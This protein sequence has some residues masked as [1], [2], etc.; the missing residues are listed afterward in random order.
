VVG[1]GPPGDGA[2]GV[3]NKD[4]VAEE[5]DREGDRAAWEGV[6]QL[7]GLCVPDTDGAVA[8]GRGDVGGEEVEGEGVG[9]G[10]CWCWC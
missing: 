1:E 4:V 8:V 5:E 2:I 7:A 9:G 6:E 3:A 10:W